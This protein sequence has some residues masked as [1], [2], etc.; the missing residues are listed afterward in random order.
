VRCLTSTCSVPRSKTHSVFV[1]ASAGS[2]PCRL[3]VSLLGVRVGSFRRSLQQRLQARAAYRVLSEHVL[4]PIILFGPCW[5]LRWQG[6]SAALRDQAFPLECRRTCDDLEGHCEVPECLASLLC[7]VS[8]CSHGQHACPSKSGGGPGLIGLHRPHSAAAQVHARQIFPSRK[9]RCILPDY[10]HSA[11]SLF[12]A[13]SNQLICAHTFGICVRAWRNGDCMLCWAR[14]GVH[15]ERPVELSAHVGSHYG[16]RASHP[17]LLLSLAA[18]EPEPVQ[19]ELQ[20]LS[21]CKWRIRP[22]ESLRFCL[23][24]ASGT[25]ADERHATNACRPFVRLVRASLRSS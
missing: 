24:T 15:G 6:S 20:S 16:A 3:C 22:L 7:F 12:C 1:T 9:V 8:A 17:E 18:L 13:V 21:K 23:T 10:C 25:H 5:P 14:L 19:C 11:C 4:W 2:A